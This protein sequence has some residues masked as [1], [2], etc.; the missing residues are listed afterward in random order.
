MPVQLVQLGAVAGLGV[1]IGVF[2]WD[3]LAVPTRE[4]TRLVTD[5]LSIDPALTDPTQC[6]VDDVLCYSRAAALSLVGVLA[7]AVALLAF[8][9]PVMKLV[10]ALI[11]RLPAVARPVLT[12]LLAT[13]V[14]TM[15][16]ANIHTEPGLVSDGFVPVEWF[17]ALVGVVTFL[18]TAFA[19]SHGGL[20]RGVFRVRDAI[21]IVAR[22]VA[23]VVLPILAA[24][25]LVGNLGW[26]ATA[27]EQAVILG[28][29]A[30]GSLAFIPAIHRSPS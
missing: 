6:G 30:V 7:V 16:Y 3:T 8:R 26:S 11:G 2:G 27:Q 13:A 10:R 28:S 12:A 15:A 5:A 4:I 19:A 22:V 25:L 9:V 23:V 17:P 14:F 18:V 29:V 21:P 24:Q 20:A 1:L